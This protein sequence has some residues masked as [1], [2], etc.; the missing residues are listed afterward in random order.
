MINGLLLAALT[1]LLLLALADARAL[2]R[3]N[4]RCR[5]IENDRQARPGLLRWY[6]DG[7]ET[8]HRLARWLLRASLA[9]ILLAVA[10]HAHPA[11][12]AA[13]VFAASLIQYERRCTASC[14]RC[15]LPATL[16]R[17]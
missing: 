9:L 3:L 17:R 7:F 11:L 8:L 13:S 2:Y 16:A 4:R 14:R 12:I 15:H 10:L 5:Q 1:V 6:A